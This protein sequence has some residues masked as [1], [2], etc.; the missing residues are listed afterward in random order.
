MTI[1]SGVARVS[2]GNLTPA[3][4]DREKGLIRQQISSTLKAIPSISSVELSIGGQVVSESLRPKTDSSVQVDGPPVVIAENRIS[5]ISGTTVARVENSPDLKGAEAS[6][7]A[8]S[9]DDSIYSYLSEGGKNLRRLKADSSEARTVLSGESLEGPSID[10]FNT[11]WTG[12][13]RTRARSSP[14]AATTR[15]TGCPRTSSPVGTCSTSRSP[16]TAHGSRCSAGRGGEPARID[17]VGIPRDRAGN[18]SS[19]LADAPLQVGSYFTEI[20]DI[21][22]A[23][24]TSLAALAQRAGETVQ[25]YR[26]GVSGPPEQLG[27]PPGGGDRIAAG[28]DG[29]S[30]LVTSDAGEIY[31]YNSNAWQKLIDVTAKDPAYPG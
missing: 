12:S 13:G 19:A 28:E 27:Q 21:S 15:S 7:P 8:V 22:W 24:S 18:P 17:V 5:R 6:D 26:V 1:E 14:S 23:G 11:I 9:F 2:L 10:R 16:A 4:T 25:P 29:R 31:S 20:R 3:P 30:I